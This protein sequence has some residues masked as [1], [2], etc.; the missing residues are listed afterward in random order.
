MVTQESAESLDAR[1]DYE[2]ENSVA[3]DLDLERVSSEDED[4]TSAPDDYQI[5]TYPADFSLDI[6]HNMWLRGGII[7]PEFHRNFVWK[8]VQSSRLIESFLIGLPVPPIYVYTQRP[9]QSYLVIDG[10]QRLKTIFYFFEGYFGETSPHG[11]KEFRL[12]GLNPSGRFNGRTFDELWPG[13]QN[14]L[15]DS[16]LRTFIIQQI[17]PSDTTSAYHIFERL[18]LGGTPL[19]NQEIRNCL[20]HGPFTESLTRLNLLPEW[21][22]ILGKG[23]PDSR[24]RD[25]ELLVRFLALRDDSSY[26][27]P[28]KDFLSQFMD[29]QQ[30]IAES[31]LA[32]DADVFHTTCIELLETLGEKPFHVRAGFN[33]AVFDAVTVAFSENLGN[34]PQDIQDRYQRLLQDEEFLTSVSNQTTDANAVWKRF[35]RARSVLFG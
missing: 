30:H 22:K 3:T 17:D 8:Q 10:Q 28:M 7:I 9:S 29:G 23:E 34:V 18:N 35:S 19:S 27:K 6:L 15:R 2:R 5:T 21:R 31:V 4:Y 13:D 11:R 16:I 14:R 12:T 20:F 32:Q 25:M 24:K 33:P 1:I 26:R